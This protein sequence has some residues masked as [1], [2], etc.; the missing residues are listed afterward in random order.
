MSRHRDK[1]STRSHLPSSTRPC[2]RFCSN[3]SRPPAGPC[4]P[5]A[6]R[7][8]RGCRRGGGRSGAAPVTPGAPPQWPLQM[9]G[10]RPSQTLHPPPATTPSRQRAC[11]TAR[12]TAREHRF[13]TDNDTSMHCTLHANTALSQTMTHTCMTH[14]VRLSLLHKQRHMHTLHTSGLSHGKI[15]TWS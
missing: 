11:R 4:C 9:L 5:A 14:S 13:V 10:A 2:H 15:T 7:R 3:A 6:P 12:I 1:P 8:A